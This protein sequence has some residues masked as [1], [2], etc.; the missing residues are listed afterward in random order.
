MKLEKEPWT[1]ALR[2]GA[3]AGSAA[4]LLSTAALAALGPR[5][6][7]SVPGPLNA[8]SHW[9]WGDES[10]R[11]DEVDLRHT[12]T[13]FVTHHLAAVFW[14]SLY[15]LLHGH[16]V[17]AKTPVQAVA[18]GVATSAVAYA[19]DYHVVPKRLTPGWEHR[20]APRSLAATYGSLAVGFALGA[21]LLGA[22]DR[23]PVD[24]DF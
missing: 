11:A 19:V 9:L 24:T 21:L 23:R 12:L 8:A 7:G 5:Q 1:Q 17:E 4:S 6:A 14:A 18:G 20:M 16:R 13:G 3:V 22:L 15:S 10:L 2:E